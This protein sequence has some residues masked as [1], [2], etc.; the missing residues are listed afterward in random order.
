VGIGYDADVDAATD[1]IRSAANELR[2]DPEYARYVLD[3]P[4]V[5]GIESLSPE[6]IVIRVVARTQPQE[7]ARVARALRARIK[8]ALDE[9]G[10]PVPSA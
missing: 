9:A 3:E 6:R 4:E 1:V 10:I 2:R 5:L 8:R 7:Q